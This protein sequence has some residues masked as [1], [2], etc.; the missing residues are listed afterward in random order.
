[1]RLVH[2]HCAT[3]QQQFLDPD[4]IVSLAVEGCVRLK[5]SF[6]LLE[7]TT[8]VQRGDQPLEGR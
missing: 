2:S 5:T 6:D 1:M 3:A 4:V 8:A 7:A